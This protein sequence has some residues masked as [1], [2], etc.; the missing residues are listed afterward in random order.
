MGSVGIHSMGGPA[1]HCLAKMTLTLVFIGWQNF[2][3]DMNHKS[4]DHVIDILLVFRGV[5]KN[6]NPNESMG[7]MKWFGVIPEEISS[8]AVYHPIFE[9]MLF[10]KLEWLFNE[11]NPSKCGWKVSYGGVHKNQQKIYKNQQEPITW[12]MEFDEGI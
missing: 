3:V 6:G 5:W 9:D 4:L 8:T 10:P 7:L 12:C 2:D 1:L 11:K